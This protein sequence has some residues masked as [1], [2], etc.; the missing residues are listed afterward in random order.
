MDNERFQ[1]K[2]STISQKTKKKELVKSIT[3]LNEYLVGIRHY[4]FK[5]LS[6][7]HQLI[8]IAEHIDEI[9]VKKIALDSKCS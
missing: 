8:L 5:V 6:N 2:L 9:L 4:Y 1:K 3:F 7:K